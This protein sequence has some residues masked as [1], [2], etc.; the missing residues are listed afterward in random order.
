M[1]QLDELVARPELRIDLTSFPVLGRAYRF[2]L[3]DGTGT[4][5]AT[6]RQRT[7]SV[8]RWLNSFLVHRGYSP[9]AV[10]D[11]IA[12]SDDLLL[13]ISKPRQYGTSLDLETTLPDGRLLG[14]VTS[15]GRRSY[16]RHGIALV[17]A[18]GETVAAMRRTAGANF[19]VEDGHG[20]ALG[21]VTTEVGGTGRYTI[22]YYASASPA[23]R[24]LTLAAAIG[25]TIQRFD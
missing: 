24:I 13:T 5:L 25:T 19:A 12:D 6:V 3:T 11:V 7:G 1:M 15:G 4:P 9:K 17:D 16:G 2:A 10:L 21:D 14:T 18:A 23:V 20:V 8:L 22:S